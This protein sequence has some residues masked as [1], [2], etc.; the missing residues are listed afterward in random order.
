MNQGLAYE[1]A[2]VMPVAFA[3]GLFVSLC[4]IQMPDGTLGDTGAPSGTFVNVMGMVNIPC[5]DAPP[6]PGHI[7]ATEVK[8][9]EEIAANAPR[10]ILLNAYFAQLASPNGVPDGWQAIIDGVVYDLL[11]AEADSQTQ[12]TRLDVRLLLV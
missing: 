10:H 3:T 2:A 11:G 8:A 9:L 1:I 12:M 7:A 4:T 6:S 5:M